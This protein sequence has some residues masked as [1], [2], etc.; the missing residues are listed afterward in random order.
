MRV[1][2]DPPTPPPPMATTVRIGRAHEPGEP[3]TN[4]WYRAL[5]GRLARGMD[6]DWHALE[7]TSHCGPQPEAASVTVGRISIGGHEVGI[8]IVTA[9]TD[10]AVAVTL[11]GAPIPVHLKPHTP[12][13]AVIA[14]AAS[15]AISQRHP[16][17]SPWRAILR[18]VAATGARDGAEAANRW[19]DDTHSTHSIA[20]SAAT[21]ML[22]GITAR[23]PRTLSGLPSYHTPRDQYCHLPTPRSTYR[24][25]A[26]QD[27][28][29]WEALSPDD[30]D[31]IAE[32]LRD[33]YDTA[34]LDALTQRCAAIASA[35]P[36]R[37]A[38][39]VRRPT[40]TDPL[41]H[42]AI[43]E[44][45]A[46]QAGFR[47][48]WDALPLTAGHHHDT[49]A[50]WLHHA[51]WT[52]ATDTQIAVFTNAAQALKDVIRDTEPADLG[53]L[54]QHLDA[55]SRRLHAA[56]DNHNHE[57]VAFAEHCDILASYR[58]AVLPVTTAT[59]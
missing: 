23:D 41:A 27:A 39:P 28:P 1:L 33:A 52:I 19:W 9:E 56:H 24:R 47:I 59:A 36:T 44:L 4:T 57:R 20:E 45:L 11:D 8:T 10:D 5:A 53:D 32:T 16:T 34:V 31:E 46:R 42:R 29:V 38:W 49:V 7:L 54:A 13:H 2:A 12:P 25:H 40:H 3:R 17:A 35:E 26:P 55:V 50:A 6:T 48:D 14:D 22:A 18:G 58:D 21:M 51:A 43:L 15:D 30:R 37:P